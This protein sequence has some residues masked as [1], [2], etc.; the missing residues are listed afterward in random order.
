MRPLSLALLLVA[1]ALALGASNSGAQDKGKA[2]GS[3]EVAPAPAAVAA[4]EAPAV[5]VEE[6]TLKSAGL[7]TDGPALLDFFRKRLPGQTDRKRLSELVEQLSDKAAGVREKA[8]SEL[9]A[10][11]PVAVPLLRQ[12]TRDPD[13]VEAA[14]LA[15]RCLQSLEGPGAAV[16]PSAAARLVAQ[17]RPAGTAEVLLAYLPYADDESVLDE[18]K[19][20]LAAVAY[21]DGKAEPALLR[22]LADDLPLR[23]ASAIDVLCQAGNAE[24]RATLRKLLNDPKPVVRIRAAL[25]LAQVKE[26]KAVSALIALLADLPP[27]QAR[28]AED[29]LYSLAAEQSPQQAP[30]TDAASRQ[31]S[32]DAWAAWWLASEGPGLLDEVRKRA[33]ADTSREKALELVRKLGDD[34]FE[35][36]EK[37]MNDLTAMGGAVV[38]VLRQAITNPDVEISARARKCLEKIEKDGNATLSPVAVRMIAYRK[39]EGAA[40]A[41]LD[42][43]PLADNDGLSG[44]IQVALN[45]LAVRDGKP[46]PAVA[47][48]LDDKSAPRRGAAAEALCQPGAEEHW[49]AVRRLLKDAEVSVRYKAAM[50]L[51]GVLER[52]AVPVLIALLGEAPPDQASVIEE[53]LIRVAGDRAPAAPGGMPAADQSAGAKKR[54]LWAAWWK[55]H[56]DKAQLLAVNR[57]TAPER[58]LGYT[59]VVMPETNQILELGTDN[60]PRWTLQGLQYPMD[61]QVLP[62]DRVL[63]AEANAARVIER[64]LKGEVV[65]QKQAN[66]PIGCQRLQNGNTFIVT[67]QQL[68]EVDR[69]GKDVAVI[70][71]PNGDVMAAQKMRNG[72]IVLVTNNS[73]CQRLDATGKELKSFRVNWVGSNYIDV[74]PNGGVLI[75]QA[76]MNKVVEYDPDGKQVWEVNVQQPMSATR[77]ANGNTLIAQ[78]WPSKV[79]EVDRNG[80]Q[81]WEFNTPNRPYRARRR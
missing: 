64:T 15:R 54:D 31:K 20:A 43:L 57:L 69:N 59:L 19:S 65:W 4:P 37:A 60:K 14:G 67:R 49:P 76:G 27:A 6:L 77:L 78:Q 45:V 40:Q 47:R 51:A 11:G 80:K 17:R 73:M 75:P 5:P 16:V 48:A 1:L 28:Q 29:F 36:R 53:Y 30:G 3:K 34:A 13:D 55:E 71:R 52:E 81:V 26:A 7:A 41:L 10:L 35:V 21:Q 12:A 33:L 46:D 70:N 23:R 61:A 44:E 24:P 72:Q 58:Y 38:P 22:A 39:P 66:W 63:I 2:A 8:A 18:V 50:G 9:V 32:R 56:G 79:I 62:G 74:L 68:L 42:F 25:A